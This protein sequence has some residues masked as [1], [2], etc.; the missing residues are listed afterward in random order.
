[1]ETRNLMLDIVTKQFDYKKKILNSK[2]RVEREQNKKMYK[3]Y[4]DIFINLYMRD[5]EII[6]YE[7]TSIKLY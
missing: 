3:F 4:R 2:T 5:K 7:R 6:E 1:M